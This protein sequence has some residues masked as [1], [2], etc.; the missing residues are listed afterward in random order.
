VDGDIGRAYREA[1]LDVKP[2]YVMELLRLDARGPMTITELA[3]SVGRTHSAISQKVSAMREAG[4]VRTSA[5]P[6]ARS[7]RVHLTRKTKG[8]VG[9]LGAEWRATER[10]IAEVESEIRYAL[11]TVV[12]DIEAA[13]ERTSFYE[14]L[15]RELAKD[16]DWS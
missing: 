10:A 16:P 14:R 7:K 9:R 13:L 6:D 15:K 12:A 1:E 4:L 3:Q 8:I 11:S 5:G 2:S